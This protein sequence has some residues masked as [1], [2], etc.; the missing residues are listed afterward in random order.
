MENERK[1]NIK[2]KGCGG[3]I[4]SILMLSITLL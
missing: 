3:G 1:I 2:T 4:A